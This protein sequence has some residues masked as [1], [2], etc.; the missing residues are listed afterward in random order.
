MVLNGNV[1]N[2]KKIIPK[3]IENALPYHYQNVG[4]Y[5]INERWYFND[6]EKI[7]SKIKQ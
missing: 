4:A 7:L 1:E 5:T 3:I 2:D 6:T